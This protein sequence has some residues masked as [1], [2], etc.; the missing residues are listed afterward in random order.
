MAIGRCF[1]EALQKG[2]RS[3]ETG[4]S[5]FNEVAIDG[6]HDEVLAALAQPRPDR[7]LV[8]GEAFR[9]GL[10]IDKI[11][12]ACRYDRWFLEQIRELDRG[13]GGGR[14]R[15]ACREMRRRCCD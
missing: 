4:L 6:S 12:A 14:E 15:A 10:G 9:R 2:L 5:G 7:V 11:Y 3:M 13:R 1:A 8:I